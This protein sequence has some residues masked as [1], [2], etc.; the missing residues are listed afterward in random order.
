MRN[1]F[2]IIGKSPFGPLAEHT[3]KVRETLTHLR[4]LMESF[5]DR[6][7]ARTVETSMTIARLEHEADE[8]KE[9]IRDHLPKSLYLP[10]DRGDLLAFLK[11]QDSIADRAEDLGELLSLRPSNAPSGLREPLLVLVDQVLEAVDAWYAVSAELRQLQEASFR[12][13]EAEKVL[14][15]IG[16]VNTAE[17]RADKKQRKALREVIAHEDALGALSVVLWMEAISLLDRIADHA[18]N[19]ADILRLMIAKA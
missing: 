8:I 2:G 9:D 10:V 16:A 18:E 6:E 12:G 3:E 11:Q 19:S 4:P 17:Y 15:M 13:A 5:L 1:I 7:E 14:R